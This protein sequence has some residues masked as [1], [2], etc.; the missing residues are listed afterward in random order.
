MN[1]FTGDVLA[2]VEWLGISCKAPELEEFLV[3]KRIHDRPMTPD[4][5]ESEGL[6]E[7]DD[8]TD[9]EYE[10]ARRSKESM[11]VQSERYGFCLIFQSR[12]NYDLVHQKSLWL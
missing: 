2:L 5:V 1:D 7:D 6:V 9:V 3:R 8:D 11:V 12:E 10:L 4:Q